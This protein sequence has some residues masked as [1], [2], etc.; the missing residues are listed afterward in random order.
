MLSEQKKDRML[1]RI[2]R[3]RK[4]YG[5]FVRFYPEGSEGD[6][7]DDDKNKDTLDSAI[8]EGEKADKEVSSDFDKEK[9]QADQA[10]A[11]AAKATKV[12]ARERDRADQA[13][14]ELATARSEAESLKEQLAAAEAKADEAGIADV[15]LDESNYEGTDLALVKSIKALNEKLDTKDKRIA[16]LEKKA[17][18]YEEQDRKDKA[19]Q[20]RKSRYEELLT[21][22]DGEYGPDCRN[23]AVKKFNELTAKGEVP[24]GN[25]AKATRIM[26]RCYKEVKA[27][28]DSK[29]KDS[30]KDKSSLTLDSGSG[31]GSTPNLTSVEIKEGSL[32]EVDAQVA[33]TSFGTRK[34]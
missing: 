6:P 10:A 9:Q 28:A 20:V 11:N 12:Y 4:V 33:K 26:E 25:T 27:A 18:S 3:L 17:T 19:L 31:G 5:P 23:E 29:S 30:A 13:E 21:D 15:E 7:D 16:Q 22:L 24:K 2:L 14:S 1:A 34:S 8:K 32:D